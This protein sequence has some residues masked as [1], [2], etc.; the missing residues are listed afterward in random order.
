MRVT[1]HKLEMDPRAT[2]LKDKG[3]N[4]IESSIII[5]DS[6]FQY[7]NWLEWTENYPTVNHL[8]FENNFGKIVF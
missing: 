3:R 4:T 2:F 8:T 6:K 5:K 1:S 7:Y